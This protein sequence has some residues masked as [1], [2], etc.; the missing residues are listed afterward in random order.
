MFGK[1][2]HPIT[3][4]DGAL[5]AEAHEF[6]PITM[7]GPVSAAFVRIVTDDAAFEPM[8]TLYCKLASVSFAETVPAES[9]ESPIA[10]TSD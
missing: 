4:I 7:A 10:I 2:E 8:K 5:T 3:S 9:A 1:T 6:P